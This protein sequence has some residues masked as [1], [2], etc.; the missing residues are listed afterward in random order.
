MHHDESDT[1]T[2]PLGD[3]LWPLWRRLT[4]LFPTWSLI[5]SGFYTP[6]AWGYFGVDF[7][8]GFRR[9]KSTRQ[10]FD[11]LSSVDNALFDALAE[12]AALNA[13]RQDQLLK[14]VVIGYVTVPLSIVAILADV[15]G[16]GML[17]FIKANPFLVGQ[18]VGAATIAPAGYLMSQWRSRQM[19]GVLDM[20][21]IE[22][23]RRGAD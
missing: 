12:L 14:V 13:R 21:R 23:C 22:R 4:R 1:R 17:A 8:S 11:L 3:D 9:N 6:G 2:A 19:I 15:T 10:V 7:V 18:I 5:P 16:D 20:V